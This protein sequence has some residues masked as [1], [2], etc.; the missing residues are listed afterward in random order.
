MNH[1]GS[2]S[3]GHYTAHAFHP[4]FR[5]WCFFNDSYVNQVASTDRICTNFAYLLFY[6][7][8][9]IGTGS[10]RPPHASPTT[11]PPTEDEPSARP[12]RRASPYI[13][14]KDKDPTKSGSKPAE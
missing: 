10:P 14:S 6:E 12:K 1:S 3:Y 7:R 8:V 13:R 9:D 5:R 4:Y 11:S 2:L